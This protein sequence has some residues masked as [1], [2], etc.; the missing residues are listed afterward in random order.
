MAMKW[1]NEATLIIEWGNYQL[2]HKD[3]VGSSLR[4][5]RIL[6]LQNYSKSGRYTSK[7]PADCSARLLSRAVQ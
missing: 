6:I 3:N 2:L 1:L 7:S 4:R 5:L